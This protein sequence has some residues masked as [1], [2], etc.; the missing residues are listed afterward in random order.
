M[1][2]DSKT[3]KILLGNSLLLFLFIYAAPLAAQGGEGTVSIQRG[4]D[5][6]KITIGDKINYTLKITCDPAIQLEPVDPAKDLYAFEIKDY[7]IKEPRK[8]RGKVVTEY[9]YLLTTFTTGHYVIPALTIGYRSQ[10]GDKYEVN[11][12]SITVYVQSVAPGEAFRGDIKPIKGP[13]S[14]KFP[15]FLYTCILLGGLLISG[16]FYF[17]Y[18]KKRKAGDFFDS[19]GPPRPPGQLAMERLEKLQGMAYLK[20]GKIKE[21]NIVVMSGFGARFEPEEKAISEDFQAAKNIIE[22]TRPK[23]TIENREKEE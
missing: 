9:H 3:A 23:V 8:K 22:M 2:I 20:E 7:S 12:P 4:V 5:K 10:G 11:S 17:N 18:K 14:I 15:W 16:L 19:A 1:K 21:G 6:N 13:V